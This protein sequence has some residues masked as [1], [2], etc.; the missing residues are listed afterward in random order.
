MAYFWIWKV[1]SSNYILGAISV[2]LLVVITIRFLAELL[3]TLAQASWSAK[4]KF[5]LRPLRSIQYG[6]TIYSLVIVFRMVST[7]TAFI[8]YPEIHVCCQEQ[9]VTRMYSSNMQSFVASKI[10]YTCTVPLSN[11]LIT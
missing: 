8:Y 6:P 11:K 7:S 9:Y 1:S 4:I 2:A 5:R 10:I 3:E